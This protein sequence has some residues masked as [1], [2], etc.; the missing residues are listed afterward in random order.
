MNQELSFTIKGLE[1]LKFYAES[2][3]GREAL[4]ET[5]AFVVDVIAR[6]P[7]D[8]EAVIGKPATITIKVAEEEA[9]IN[10]IVSTAMAT[11]PTASRDFC[12]RFTVEPEVS[13]MR[14]SGQNQV[15]STET[16]VTV[17]DIVEKELSDANKAGSKTAGSRPSRTMNYEVL[18]DSASYPKLDFVMQYGESDFDF[19]SR[20]CEKFGIFYMFDTSGSKE[21]LLFCDR[22]EHFRKV[23]GRTVGLD[24]P[25]R[26]EMQTLSQGELAIRSFHA[27]CRAQ[28]ATVA[29]REYNDE[30]PTVDLGV[31][32]SAGF[33]GFGTRVD[34]GQNYRNPAE[35]RQ[36]AQKRTELLETERLQYHGQS[37]IP[38]LRPGVFFKLVDHPDAALEK[39]YVVTEVQHDLTESLHLHP[40]RHPIPPAAQDAEAGDPRH[41]ARYRRWRDQ[42]RP[43]RTG[44]IWPLPGAY[45][46]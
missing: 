39:I 11:D 32:H 46:R 22:K 20:L 21:T 15:Y 17:M 3:S 29:M 34:Y 1:D 43:R 44:Q 8:I 27:V 35:G 5:Y 38:N 40:V 10:G 28:T 45:P 23:D 9:V 24:L 26:G 12:F 2:L 18:L 4:S 41:A 37:D 36:L 16:S 7:V 6:K 13:L 25:F 33:Q 30:T 31:S 42:Q 14:L 19:I